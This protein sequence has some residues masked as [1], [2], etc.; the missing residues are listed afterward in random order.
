VG[1]SEFQSFNFELNVFADNYNLSPLDT[2]YAI[3][4]MQEMGLININENMGRASSAKI[5]IDQ[6]ELYKFMIANA[7]MEPIMKALLRLYGGVLYTDFTHIYEFEIAKICKTNQSDVTKKL[8][9]LHKM[10]VIIYDQLKTKPQLTYLTPR[11]D[12]SALKRPYIQAMK[13]RKIIHEKIESMIRYAVSEKVCR[14][15]IFQEY[16]N[17]A[18][19]MNCGN[20]DI[21]ISAKKQERLIDSLDEAKSKILDNLKYLPSVMD[22][23]KSQVGITDDFL[24]SEAIRELIDEE[25]VEMKK[26]QVFLKQ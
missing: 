14:T 18:T 15:R 2:H 12:V 21:C 23:L 7:G 6:G 24:F 4:K 1:S 17:E 10:D 25:K 11:L 8:R 13:R 26:L 20:C 19:Y 9:N 22:E 16:F 3:L 5:N